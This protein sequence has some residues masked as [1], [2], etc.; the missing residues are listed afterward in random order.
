MLQ[1]RQPPHQRAAALNIGHAPKSLPPDHGRTIDILVKSVGHFLG[2]KKLWQLLG[3]KRK[4][5]FP[6]VRIQI[7]NRLTNF[8][9]RE[10]YIGRGMKLEAILHV[11]EEGEETVF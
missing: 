6:L 2:S 9:K 10:L 4:V 5:W 8:A 11:V 1:H 3:R 7:L